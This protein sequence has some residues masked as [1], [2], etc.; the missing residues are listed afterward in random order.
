VRLELKLLAIWAYCVGIALWTPAIGLQIAYVFLQPMDILVLL[1]L[2]FLFVFWRT[3]PVASVSIVALGS[4]SAVLSFKADGI[5]MVL[6][7]YLA[8][9]SPFLLLVAIAAMQPHATKMFFSGFL[10]GLS[11]SVI[12]NA[13]QLVFGA[14]HFD[15][16][17]NGLKP[18][19]SSRSA[20]AN[21]LLIFSPE[22]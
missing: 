20:S 10:T 18:P 6:I 17:P 15:F 5:V 19:A 21:L 14:E 22:F 13:V 11:I 2:P 1:G 16:P 8:L 12:L 7:Y 4:I 9:I 3:I